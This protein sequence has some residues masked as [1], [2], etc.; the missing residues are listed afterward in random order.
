LFAVASIPAGICAAVARRRGRDSWSAPLVFV[1]Q[2]GGL[3]ALFFGL[4]ALA[5]D[6]YVEDYGMTPARTMHF[7]VPLLAIAVMSSA[8]AWMIALRPQARA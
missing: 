8:A 6:G 2:L 4:M 3:F 7:A 5:L 1:L